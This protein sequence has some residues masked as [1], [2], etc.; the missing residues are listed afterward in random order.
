MD[1]NYL[2]DLLLSIAQDAA[3]EW[4]L[5]EAMSGKLTE[6]GEL[7]PIEMSD[8]YNKVVDEYEELKKQYVDGA[9]LRR[10]KMD[11][12][13]SKAPAYDYHFR[14]ILKHRATAFVL[15][16]EAFLADPEDEMLERIMIDSEERFWWAVKKFLGVEDIPN[17]GRCLS[18]ELNR[19]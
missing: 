17:C 11:V 6:L 10:K 18:D 14:C 1:R 15:A 9:V 8:L 13:A 2:I 5:K 16:T 4:H 19:K 12:L 7:D 3:D